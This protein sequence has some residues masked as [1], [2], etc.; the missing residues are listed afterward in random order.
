M[1]TTC[2][3]MHLEIITPI[4]IKTCL[5]KLTSQLR[6]DQ[7][8]TI[9]NRLT[10]RRAPIKWTGRS[11]R[12]RVKGWNWIQRRSA[13][14]AFSLPSVH[15]HSLFKAFSCLS[16]FIQSGAHGSQLE[17]SG[18]YHAASVAAAS[19]ASAVAAAPVWPWMWHAATLSSRHSDDSSG[20]CC[21]L[22]T[23]T[24]V[25]EACAGWR[26]L[27]VPKQI[28]EGVS[29]PNQLHVRLGL[30]AAPSARQKPPHAVSD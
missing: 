30:L 1:Q 29:G 6:I 7:T 9:K 28:K 19:A 22:F 20:R 14:A 24:L 17:R 23:P 27:L 26:A 12:W 8:P 2:R 5:D 13:S 10:P 15:T 3:Q 18:F 25:T 16:A 4:T 11:K 21:N